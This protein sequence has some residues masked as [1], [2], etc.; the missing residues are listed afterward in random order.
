MD[1]RDIQSHTGKAK[2]DKCLYIRT[3]EN[4]TLDVG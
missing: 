3:D 2:E 1:S 4:P